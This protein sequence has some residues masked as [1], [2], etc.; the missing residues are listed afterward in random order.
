MPNA[1]S[2]THGA[3]EAF[4]IVKQICLCWDT[5][6]VLC[7]T[8]IALASPACPLNFFS[9]YLHRE[10]LSEGIGGPYNY[11]EGFWG[12]KGMSF[13]RSISCQFS[14]SLLATKAAL[15]SEDWPGLVAGGAG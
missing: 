10:S 13:E 3:L 7:A 5:T 15:A 2:A 4:D 12:P 8:T 11:C 1:L 14:F 9:S 6:L